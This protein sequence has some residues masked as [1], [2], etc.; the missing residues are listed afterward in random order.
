MEMT[1][2]ALVAAAVLLSGPSPAATIYCTISNQ[3][4]RICDDGRNWRSTEWKGY[5]GVTIWQ[6]NG[7]G[8]QRDTSTTTSPLMQEPLR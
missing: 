3:G 1:K 4:Y 8:Q 6:D 5:G 2:L 7:G